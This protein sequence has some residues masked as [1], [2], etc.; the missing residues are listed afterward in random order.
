MVSI[1]MV[2]ATEEAKKVSYDGTS[3]SKSISFQTS[4][5]KTKY[6][7]ELQ[8]SICTRVT[9][10]RTERVCGNVTR[11]VEECRNIPADEVCNDVERVVCHDV[12]DY[13]EDCSS[14]GSEVVCEEINGRRICRTVSSGGSCSS[15]PTTRRVCENVSDV[16]CT[17]IPAH[18]ECENVARTSYECHNE[19][20]NVTENYK[21][22][23]EVQVPYN[24]TVIKNHVI[25]FKF[26]DESSSQTIMD[27][28]ATKKQNG[29]I[30]VKAFDRSP[31]TNS[32][33]ALA[34]S[35]RSSE[36]SVSETQT[37]QTTTYN[38]RFVN[39]STIVVGKISDLDFSRRWAKFLISSK[40][41]NANGIQIKMTLKNLEE[42]NE[43]FNGKVKVEAI[44]VKAQSNGKTLVSIDFDR[45]GISPDSAD[46]RIDISAAA[47]ASADGAIILNDVDLSDL[48]A[49]KALLKEI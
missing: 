24:I 19:T 17:N 22:K 34:T 4:E 3:N 25:D 32:K 13:D 31:S 14:G 12:T 27:F 7:T 28:V 15:Y 37:K 9:G 39:K 5:V 33:L 18:R 40:I 26:K 10:T 43:I 35:A 36:I 20:V 45:L 41:E 29:E 16:E 38:V 46:H 48:A 30:V 23:K 44:A 11:Y 42:N 8:D 21:C 47:N 6:R 1:S 49:S 2:F